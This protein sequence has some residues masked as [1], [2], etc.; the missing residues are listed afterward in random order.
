[1]VDSEKRERLVY[2]DVVKAVSI[3]MIMMGHITSLPNPMDTLMSSVKIT[4]FYVISGFLMAYTRS[5]HRRTPAQFTTNLLKTLAWPY[6]TFSVAAIIAKFLV[7]YSKYQDTARM[8]EKGLEAIRDTVFLKGIHSI[9]FL[10]TLFFGELIILLLFHLPKI[11]SIL[12]ACAAPFVFRISVPFTGTVAA[13]GYSELKTEFLKDVIL[14]LSKSV[15]AAW[16]IGFGYLLL[17]LFKKWNILTGHYAAKFGAG[18]VLSALNVLAA[19][20]NHK[21]N[22]NAMYYGT[23]PAHF[24]IGGTI[25]VIGLILL[26]DAVTSKVP[27]NSLSYWGKNSL[28]LMCTHVPLGFKKIARSGWHKLAKIPDQV[29]IGYYIHCFFVLG[30]LLLMMYGLCELINNHFP[31]MTRF[32]ESHKNKTTSSKRA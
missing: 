2:I 4:A 15:S 16:F 8:M 17:L 19:S 14:V 31:F 29:C 24:F 18:I 21:I 20:Y 12:Y 11:F 25:G 10:P 26:A 30:V 1:M 13:A 7:V 6:L 28:I 32:P 5:L 3:M 9:W 23:V 27:L 22:F